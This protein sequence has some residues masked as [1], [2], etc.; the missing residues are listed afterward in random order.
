MREF[1]TKVSDYLNERRNNPERQED[2]LAIVIVGVSAAV[3]IVLLL[4]VLW[5]HTVRERRDREAQAEAD[6]MMTATTYEEH[7]EEYMSHNDVQDELNREYMTSIEYLGNQV[8]E[9]LTALTQVEQSLFETTEQYQEGD[10]SLLETMASLHT[11]ITDIVQNL[12]KTQ[13]E[14]YDLM[15]VIQV[16]NEE[17][18]S[19]IQAQITQVRDDIN[20]VSGDIIDMYEKIA[21][22]EQEDDKLRKS[23]GNMEQIIERLSDRIDELAY[24][25]KSSTM[26]ALNQIGTF[27]ASVDGAITHNIADNAVSPDGAAAL[28]FDSLYQGILQS[29]SVAHLA[30]INPA[31]ENNLPKGTAAW[32]NGSLIIGNGADIADSYNRGFADGYAEKM[33]DISIEYVYHEHTGNSTDGGGCYGERVAVTVICTHAY[34]Y[35][36]LQPDGMHK[37]YGL[38][39]GTHCNMHPDRL[40]WYITEEA[41]QAGVRGSGQHSIETGYYYALNCGKT[42]DT[43]ESAT[44]VFP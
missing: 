13:T 24:T 37:C 7:A 34:S 28:S 41:F 10:S 31:V 30:D 1:M 26:E 8:E 42:E 6:N 17:T 5:G 35:D 44:I 27:Y 19:M 14:L 38:Y 20:Q 12:H 23:I 40:E 29:Q 36:E 39:E 4:L 21:K 11:Q 18:I 3:V 22:L 2:R 33:D 9:L 32:V 16:M 15:D 43:I 25:Y